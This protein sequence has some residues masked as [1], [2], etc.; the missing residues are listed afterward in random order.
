MTEENL[1]TPS[2][3]S[4]PESGQTE[5]GGGQGGRT[6]AIIIIVVVLLGLIAIAALA[7]SGNLSGD[8]P[9]EVVSFIEIDQPEE[10]AVLDVPQ[11][12]N[13]NGTA[14]GLFEGNLVV[15]A[16][17]QD[18][19]VLAQQPTTI[20]ALDAGT[21]GA[22]PWSVE[23][24]VPVKPGSPGHIYAFS[25]SP[26]DGSILASAD[27]EVTFG[28][29]VAIESYIEIS[30]PQAGVALDAT[31]PI[32]VSGT[33][34]GLIEGNVVVEARDADGNV[35]AQEATTVDSP[36]AGTG[37]EGPWSVELTIQV[38]GEVPAQIH[39][40]SPSPADGSIVASSSVDVTLSGET[41]AV[42]SYITIDEPQDGSVLDISNPVTVSGMGGGLF[43]GNVVVEA[44]DA[45]GNVLVQDATILDSP[46]AGIGGEGSWSI[47]LT[48]EVTPGTTGRVRAFSPSPVDGSDMASDQV[49]VTYGEGDMEQIEV[50]LE[51]HLWVLASLGGEDVLEGTQITA[52]FKDGQVAGSAGCNNYFASYESAE[53]TLVIGPAGLTM[54]FCGEPEGVMDQETQYLGALESVATYEIED[55]LLKIYDGDGEEIMTYN[56][57]VTGTVTYLQRIALP[58]DAVVEVKLADVSLADAPAT[59]IGE[60]TITNPGQVPIP[61]VVTYDPAVIDPRFTY[62][63]QVRIND[64]TGNLLWINTSAYNVI[65][66]DNPSTVEVV[67]DQVS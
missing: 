67:V 60:Q 55:G 63:I 31:K 64:G 52:E 1:N 11:P 9:Q 42:E 14:G 49:E 58:E 2:M 12:V 25:L 23:L 44:L 66:N 35:L 38:Q 40:F 59:V 18:G 21:G 61:F 36:D 32:M 30:E 8:Q 10:G 5:N 65:T 53:N 22:G 56:A 54:M 27:I 46:D 45:N 43:E 29:E 57:A 50:K 62:A 20:D 41:I 51:D 15:Q 4:T 13:I 24:V 37:G 19:N 17:D 33:G 28:E 3:E 48:L 16:L 7:V 34:G 39:A 26:D 47:Q 6:A